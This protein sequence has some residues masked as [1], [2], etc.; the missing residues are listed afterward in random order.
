VQ[1]YEVFL[2]YTTFFE[3]KLEKSWNCQ[4]LLVI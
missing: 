4:K 1:S 3:K 2:K